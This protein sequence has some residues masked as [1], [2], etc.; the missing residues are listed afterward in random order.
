MSELE[1]R[2]AQLASIA[3][4]LGDAWHIGRLTADRY[5]GYTLDLEWD[6]PELDAEASEQPDGASLPKADP[7][8]EYLARAYSV[9]MTGVPGFLKLED[10]DAVD[11]LIAAL[12]ANGPTFP[13]G[14]AIASAYNAIH[15]GA[16]QDAIYTYV[17]D[18]GPEELPGTA[19]GVPYWREDLQWLAD[20]WPEVDCY[21]TIGDADIYGRLADIPEPK[22]VANAVLVATIGATDGETEVEL[23]YYTEGLAPLERI[24]LCNLLCTSRDGCYAYVRY[25]LMGGVWAAPSEDCEDRE[26]ALEQVL[27]CA[28]DDMQAYYD[29]SWQWSRQRELGGSY[30]SHDWALVVRADWLAQAEGVSV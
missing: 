2:N 6:G 14:A 4:Q 27:E 1:Q 13:N 8:S 22:D 28:S 16:W 17:E 20:L 25:D 21:T 26:A 18:C 9:V 7:M 30:G 24:L 11:A 3:D 15:Y 29:C 23:E 10:L 5:S 12:E 19:D